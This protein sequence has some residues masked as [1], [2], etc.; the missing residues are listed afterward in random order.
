MVWLQRSH[1]PEAFEYEVA[2]PVAWGVAWSMW[3]MG[4]SHQGVLQVSSRRVI[5]RRSR[6]SKVRRWESIATR[7]PVVGVVYRR[8]I[9]ARAFPDGLS[10]SGES[11]ARA[12][13][14]GRGKAW[15]CGEEEGDRSG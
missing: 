9:Q 10:W 8:R 4:A 7:C 6:P 11:N 13:A 14:A 3:R 5:M 12:A 1:K 15:A 2:P